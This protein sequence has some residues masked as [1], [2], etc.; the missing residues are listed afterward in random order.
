MIEPL[1]ELDR[2]EMGKRNFADAD[3]VDGKGL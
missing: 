2:V 3:K 1:V